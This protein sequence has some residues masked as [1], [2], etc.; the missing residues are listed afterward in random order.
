[1]VPCKPKIKAEIRS[2]NAN[3]TGFIYV[4]I[5]SEQKVSIFECGKKITLPKV[6]YY[7]FCN[8]ND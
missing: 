5:V 6:G 8:S 3:D 2:I 7:Y 1:M 4:P